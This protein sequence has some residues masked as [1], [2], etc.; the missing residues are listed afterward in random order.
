MPQASV[1]AIHVIVTNSA[2]PEVT[3][4]FSR[5]RRAGFVDRQEQ[6]AEY[7]NADRLAQL[8]RRG[9]QPAGVGRLVRR[10][11][12]ERL[13]DERAERYRE[14]SAHGHEEHL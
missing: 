3:G 8:Y 1:T 14:K 2:R 4:T 9:Q 6:A 13:G 10:H 12:D 11:P 7:R 5:P